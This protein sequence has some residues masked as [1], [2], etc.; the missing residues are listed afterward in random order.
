MFDSEYQS[1]EKLIAVFEQTFYASHQTR[2]VRGGDEPVYLPASRTGTVNQIVFAR[3][4]F[5]SGLH[6]I[7]H[8]CVAG[9]ERRLLEDFGYW[10]VPD[11]RNPT[12]QRAF[13]K[14]E[15][16]PQAYEQCFTLAAGR[17]FNISADNLTGQPGATYS[18]ELNVHRLTL[19]LLFKGQLAGRAQQFF[20]ALCKAWQN[21]FASW[22]LD[23]YKTLTERIA[24][25]EA[26]L[27]E[28][29]HSEHFE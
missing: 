12:Q 8:W 29:K 17:K 2:L 7:A 9:A 19:Q 26:S 27:E 5:S 4:F 3:G 25:L 23:A 24:W 14:V 15:V 13:E 11:G 10:Y 20:D 28:L 16:R 18:F 6:E 22:Q 1:C 21:P